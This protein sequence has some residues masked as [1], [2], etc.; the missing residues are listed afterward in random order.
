MSLS[1]LGSSNESKLSSSISA[2]LS[3]CG[4]STGDEMYGSCVTRCCLCVI[5]GDTWIS[6][7]NCAMIRTSVKMVP[8]G[9]RQVG[10]RVHHER[11]TWSRGDVVNMGYT[12]TMQQ[13]S[14]A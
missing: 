2:V 5:G 12:S 13:Q 10:V 9:S 8:L 1:V 3:T 11:N 7:A 6:A 4:V 14:P